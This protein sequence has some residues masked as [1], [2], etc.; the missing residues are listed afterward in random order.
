V[1]GGGISHTRFHAC[2]KREE[3]GG[4]GKNEMGNLKTRTFM[5]CRGVF[6]CSHAVGENGRERLER[7]KTAFRKKE[8]EEGKER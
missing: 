2:K 8:K 6:F 1:K 7:E 4:E 3:R 5:S